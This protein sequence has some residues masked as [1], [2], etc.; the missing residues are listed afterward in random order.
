MYEHT[1]AQFSAAGQQFYCLHLNVCAA[2]K[3]RELNNFVS[4]NLARSPVKPIAAPLNP[5][6]APQTLQNHLSPSKSQGKNDAHSQNNGQVNAAN[7]R[8]ARVGP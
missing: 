4:F 7:G 3:P 5:F 6:A 1:N 2:D 8:P